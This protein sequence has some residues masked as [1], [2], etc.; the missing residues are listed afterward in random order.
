MQIEISSHGWEE[1]TSIMFFYD[2]AG[3]WRV[4][5]TTHS[6]VESSQLQLWGS[7]VMFIQKSENSIAK[8]QSELVSESEIDLSDSSAT[9]S[10]LDSKG[11]VCSS[12]GELWIGA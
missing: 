2:W 5:P 10:L 4:H 3:Y 1:Q 12:K 8:L 7:L 11:G 6:T 9:P